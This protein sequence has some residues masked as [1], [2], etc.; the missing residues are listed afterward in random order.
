[1]VWIHLT[2]A[3]VWASYVVLCFC[4]VVGWEKVSPA[5]PRRLCITGLLKKNPAQSRRRH[6][7]F[8]GQPIGQAAIT[9]YLIHPWHVERGSTCMCA[10][11]YFYV[12]ACMPSNLS[13]ASCKL[14]P[15]QS[16]P[17]STLFI[18]TR[19]YF[20]SWTNYSNTPQHITVNIILRTTINN[21]VMYWKV[22][23]YIEEQ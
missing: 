14:K 4:C 17:V 21:V 16:P 19:R 15:R 18:P 9:G 5:M 12:F 22:I 23:N 8:A 10:E 13:A 7:S 6:Y 2:A 11:M 3:T 1:M 20:L